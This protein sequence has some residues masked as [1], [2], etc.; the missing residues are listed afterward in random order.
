GWIEFENLRR[1]PQRSFRLLDTGE[2]F[3][4]TPMQSDSFVVA[5][6][7]GELSF[8]G[9]DD[10]GVPRGSRMELVQQLER[11]SPHVG[12]RSVFVGDA[13]EYLT[14]VSFVPAGLEKLFDG[15]VRAFGVVEGVEVSGSNLNPRLQS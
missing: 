9:R 15:Q 1:M 11:L 5:L 2:N 3:D 8:N 10:V 7:Q 13:F 6:S 12:G 14:T 4:G